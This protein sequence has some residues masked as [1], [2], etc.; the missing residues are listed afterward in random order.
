MRFAV[1]AWMILTLALFFGCSG[2]KTTPEQ[3]A[4]QSTAITSQEQPETGSAPTEPELPDIV[5]NSRESAMEAAKHNDLRIRW[6][7]VA[8]LR[9]NSETAFA[10]LRE[11]LNSPYEDVACAAVNGLTASGPKDEVIAVLVEQLD[12]PRV[13]VQTEAVINLGE[14]GPPAASAIPAITALIQS[15]DPRLS[16]K[17]KIALEKINSG[18]G[19]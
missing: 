4:R 12:H 6:K 18:S 1:F 3:P 13:A 9:D 2:E 5:I 19:S 10:D 8:Y 7:A 15:T 16:E 17:A 14:I 11:L